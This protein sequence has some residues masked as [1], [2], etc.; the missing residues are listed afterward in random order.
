MR[1]VKYS[2]TNLVDR[3]R[4]TMPILLT[5]PH[6]G[7]SVVPGMPLRSR[8][9]TPSGCTGRETFRDGRDAATADITEGVASSIL[10]RTGLSPYVVIARFSRK[11]VD[12]NRSAA[13]A[14]SNPAFA[15]YYNEYHSRIAGY[16]TQL[17][18]QNASQGFLFDVHG[19]NEISS[20]PADLYIGTANGATLFGGF[21]RDNLFAR[22]GL[23]QLLAGVRRVEP[24]RYDFRYRV[25]PARASDTETG[26]VNGA[27]TV[28]NYASLI[29]CVQIE[30]ADTIRDSAQLRQLLIEDL[31]FA[32]PNFVR[33]Y[34]PF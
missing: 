31:S 21:N 13:C 16:I 15:R 33:R 17:Q 20:D 2:R 4:G 26:A 3:H 7:G 14:F 30:V 25:S 9:S 22:H 23:R 5:C 11:M 12:A 32:I 6:D 8:S 18:A 27:F 10:L 28:R 34:A 29:S 19:T 1:I 24:Y